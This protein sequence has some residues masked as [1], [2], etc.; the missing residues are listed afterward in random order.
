[1]I[2][3]LHPDTS[4]AYGAIDGRTVPDLLDEIMT[5]GQNLAF[6]EAKWELKERL[7]QALAAALRDWTCRPKQFLSSVLDTL[8]E[9]LLDAGLA[10]ELNFADQAEYYHE[11]A[12]EHGP[13]KLRVLWLQGPLVM[14][15]QSPWT[16]RCRPCSPCVP[17]AGDLDAP[18]AEGTTAYCVPPEWLPEEWEGPQPELQVQEP[19]AASANP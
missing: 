14:V 13:V 7:E 2:P 17:N 19:Q 8:V 4:I 6:E 11:M 5:H 16:L 15:L 10:E 18:H 12:T 3:N 9:E 1:M